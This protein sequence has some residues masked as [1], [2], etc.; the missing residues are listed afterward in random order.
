MP[1]SNQNQRTQQALK[2]LEDMAAHHGHSPRIHLDNHASPAQARAAMSAA[3]LLVDE[4]IAHAEPLHLAGNSTGVAAALVEA[5]SW[6]GHI[7]E[8]ED[9]EPQP[10]D[11]D[12]P[13]PHQAAMQ[14]AVQRLVEATQRYQETVER[15]PASDSILMRIWRL[16]IAPSALA[17]MLDHH[18]QT[19]RQADDDP[20]IQAHGATLLELQGHNIAAQE[21]AANIAHQIYELQEAAAMKTGGPRPSRRQVARCIHSARE[22]LTRFQE[23]AEHLYNT[24]PVRIA[25]P[26]AHIQEERE[27]AEMLAQ[28]TLDH[29]KDFSINLRPLQPDTTLLAYRS[30]IF[31]RVKYITGHY[32]PEDDPDAVEEH[33]INFLNMS[34]HVQE[35]HGPEAAAEHLRVATMVYMNFVA[36]LQDIDR[37]Q[38]AHFLNTMRSIN[39][40]TLATR[41]AANDALIHDTSGMDL[42]FHCTGPSRDRPNDT[43][44]RTVIDAA[45]KAGL[46]QGQLRALC[47]ALEAEPA[48]MGVAPAQAGSQEIIE[49]LGECPAV[50]HPHQACTIIRALGGDDQDP[51]LQQWVNNNCDEEDKE[52]E[53]EEYYDE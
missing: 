36:D 26:V 50:L 44:A 6:L 29:G 19:L 21:T 42:L 46:T 33:A 22:A 18:V 12:Q 45:R 47:Q 34:E 27:E 43:Q 38:F 51:E 23:A 31:I 49:A 8:M 39:D 53:D 3:P 48:A 37:D 32:E 13:E 16:T 35:H 40:D 52:D 30:G 28:E 14:R 10:A 25:S 5:H 17:A 15:S 1:T 4:I 11:S 7:Q 41:Y 24:T 2:A 9:G 20:D